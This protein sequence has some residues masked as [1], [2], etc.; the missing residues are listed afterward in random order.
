MFSYIHSTHHFNEPLHRLP[1]YNPGWS[2]SPEPKTTETERKNNI[3]REFNIGFIHA[4]TSG[5]LQRTLGIMCPHA[6]KA[7]GVTAV[8]SHA[9]YAKYRR[10]L[11]PWASRMSAACTLGA[12]AATA[13]VYMGKPRDM[14]EGWNTLKPQEY[15]KN[16]IQELA[17]MIGMQPSNRIKAEQ[18]SKEWAKTISANWFHRLLSYTYPIFTTE[19]SAARKYTGMFLN[20]ANNYPQLFYCAPK[21]ENTI[22]VPLT[23]SFITTKKL[24]WF[25]VYPP[26]TPWQHARNTVL[27]PLLCLARLPD[28]WANYRAPL[29]TQQAGTRYASVLRLHVGKV[30][31][32]Q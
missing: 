2:G 16:T 13:L 10:S 29:T 22:V 32:P 26:Q 8:V 7:W 30:N 6:T 9:L 21:G 14:T 15:Y 24:H 18:I 1:A 27:A 17:K 28:L 25:A 12:W 11:S 23:I 5:Y 3:S 4:G 19:K 31:F 20:P